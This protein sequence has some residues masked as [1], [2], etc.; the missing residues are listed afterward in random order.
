MRF[1]SA[2]KKIHVFLGGLSG[3]T[4]IELL[5]VVAVVGVIAGAVI[6]IINPNA[7]F[8]RGR[9]VKRKADIHAIKQALEEY[10][11]INGTYPITGVANTYTW[12]YSTAGGTW[13]PG[14]TSAF[15]KTL[16]RDPINSGG[17]PWDAV[18]NNYTYAYASN[19]VYYNLVARLE[20]PS[21]PDRCAV[22]QWFFITTLA[23]GGSI[24]CGTYST[25]I[26]STTNLNN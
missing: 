9:D 2:N 10:I 20:S 12:V 5:V 22:K 8:A 6:A 16:P 18:N 3:F 24:W 14:L 19:G 1:L 15:I 23:G 4:L 25:Q 26:Y 7:Q 17:G 21:D 11:V 13:I